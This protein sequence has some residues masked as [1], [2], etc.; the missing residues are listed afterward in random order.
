MPPVAEIAA[1]VLIRSAGSCPKLNPDEFRRFQ[2]LIH[3]ETGIYLRE[4]KNEMLSSRLIR[5]VRALNLRSFREYYDFVK[6]EGNLSPELRHMI[7]AVTTNM[8]SFFREAAHFKHLGSWIEERLA[9]GQRRFRFWSA[10]S[11]TGEEAYT[12]AITFAEA[13][14]PGIR[15]IDLRILATDIDTDVLKHAGSGVYRETD[16]HSV[17]SAIKTRYFTCGRGAETGLLKVRKELRDLIAF[18]RLNLIESGWPFRGPFDAIF[19]RNVLIY[20]DQ[21]T[22]QALIRRMIDFLSPDGHLF[23][24]HSESLNWAHSLLIPVCHAGYR[25]RKSSHHAHRQ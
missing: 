21:Q 18:R 12:I 14:P 16:M 7:N 13:L 9:Q 23:V 8:T 20:F 19:C 25:L 10:A 11:S 17:A 24:G 6:R 5:R 1:P 2:S 22:Q 4:T 3:R 15:D